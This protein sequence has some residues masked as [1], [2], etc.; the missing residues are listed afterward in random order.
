MSSLS[1]KHFVKIAEILNNE[2]KEAEEK[3]AI[4]S[5]ITVSRIAIQL[6]TYFKTQNNQFS[7]KKFREAVYKQ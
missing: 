7:E 5:K 4:N 6:S 3:K 2:L 1:K